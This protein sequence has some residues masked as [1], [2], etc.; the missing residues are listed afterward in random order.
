MAVKHFDNEKTEKSMDRETGPG[1]SS[2]GKV[3]LLPMLMALKGKPNHKM[4]KKKGCK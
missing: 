4:M 2:K 3:N 1:E